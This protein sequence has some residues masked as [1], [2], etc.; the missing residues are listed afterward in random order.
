MHC[1]MLYDEQLALAAAKGENAKLIAKKEKELIQA[2]WAASQGRGWVMGM[3]GLLKARCPTCACMPPVL[4][5]VQKQKTLVETLHR[6]G[7]LQKMLGP[8][9]VSSN[10]ACGRGCL[11]QAPTRRIASRLEWPCN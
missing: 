2:S 7:E 8:E 10:W 1:R 6:C 3:V 5:H 9:P 4:P 11:L